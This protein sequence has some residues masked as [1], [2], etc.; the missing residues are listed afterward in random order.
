MTFQKKMDKTCSFENMYFTLGHFQRLF[1]CVY[2]LYFTYTFH[3]PYIIHDVY[4]NKVWAKP[5][6]SVNSATPVRGR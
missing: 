6:F 5:L 2:N 1:Y 4:F 3:F